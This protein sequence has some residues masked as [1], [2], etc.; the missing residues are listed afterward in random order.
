MLKLSLMI[1]L[2]IGVGLSGACLASNQFV[3]QAL[4]GGM[5]KYVDMARSSVLETRD[6]FNNVAAAVESATGM[7]GN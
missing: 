4:P 1:A 5:L 2:V 7:N 3:S 6:T